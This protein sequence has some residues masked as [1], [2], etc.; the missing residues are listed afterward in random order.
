MMCTIAANVLKH[1]VKHDLQGMQRHKILICNAFPGLNH[2]INAYLTWYGIAA[3]FADGSMSTAARA[4]VL[5]DFQLP[6]AHPTST[7]SHDTQV[8]N[9]FGWVMVISMA[10]AQGVNLDRGD[11]MILLVG[12]S[13]QHFR[14]ILTLNYRPRLGVPPSFAN[15]RAAAIGT[16]LNVM[17]GCSI[18]SWKDL[19]TNTCTAL[20]RTS[21]SCHWRS[22]PTQ[23]LAAAPAKLMTFWKP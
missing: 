16:P 18:S 2:A 15:L 5:G 11:V 13:N 10:Y 20:G 6:G 7:G 1:D 17:S 4:K 22:F 9:G 19:R 3:S 21:L 23:T 14:P 12:K 8:S